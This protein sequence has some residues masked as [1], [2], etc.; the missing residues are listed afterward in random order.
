[1]AVTNGSFE[2]GTGGQATDWTHTTISATEEYAPF[3]ATPVDVGYDTFD[4]YAALISV[5][6]GIYVDI[7]PAIFE[8]GPG[9]EPYEDFEEGWGATALILVLSEEL[10]QFG[11]VPEQFD[12]F[13]NGWGDFWWD[14]ASAG[15]TAALFDSGT[16]PYDQFQW[17]G[18]LNP[19]F[20][21]SELDEALFDN[22]LGPD[23]FETFGAG[24]WPPLVL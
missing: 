17:L 19:D 2:D 23:P 1:M 16:N 9:Q 8:S 10:A 4:W 7:D 12:S 11:S 5:Y 14:L 24:D 3:D 22:G 13:E 21:P 20:S 15:S 18:A 6:E